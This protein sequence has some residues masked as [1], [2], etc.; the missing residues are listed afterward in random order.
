MLTGKQKAKL[1]ALANPLSSKYQV[2]KGDIDEQTISLLDKGLEANELIK[3]SVLKTSP[4][5]V[6]KVATDLSGKLHC[7]V[8]QTIGR[9][10]SLYRPSKEK[11]IRF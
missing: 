10:I 5:T 4:E 1:K 11:K 8:V 6:K 2:G 3:V 7:E 9:V